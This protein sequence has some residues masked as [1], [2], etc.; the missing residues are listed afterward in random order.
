MAQNMYP[1]YEGRIG[2]GYL[3]VSLLRALYQLS[4]VTIYTYTQ[5]N[6]YIQIDY[7]MRNFNGRNV[8]NNHILHI[9]LV[10]FHFNATTPQNKTAILSVCGDHQMH[11]SKLYMK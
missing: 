6:T 5:T 8:S 3:H 10:I 11:S 2:Y 9:C 7:D 1:A 4:W